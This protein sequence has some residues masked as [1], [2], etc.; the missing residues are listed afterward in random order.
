MLAPT[1]V[2]IMIFHFEYKEIMIFVDACSDRCVKY[3][4]IT[5][6]DHITSFIEAYPMG[7]VQCALCILHLL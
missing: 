4:S 3:A 7:V 2:N 6:Y 1:S 5:N